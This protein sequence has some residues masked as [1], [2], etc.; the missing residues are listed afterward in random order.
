MEHSVDPRPDCKLKFVHFG[1]V[2]KNRSIYQFWFNRGGPMKFNDEF[3]QKIMFV[4]VRGLLFW[5]LTINK[6]E[7]ESVQ[8]G[9]TYIADMDKC[10]QD[11]CCLDKCRVDCCNLLYMF[12]G[13]LFKV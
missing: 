6:T 1:P 13:P 8:L 9:N 4:K 3:F 11:K 5:I 7:V 10:P 2:E 12:P